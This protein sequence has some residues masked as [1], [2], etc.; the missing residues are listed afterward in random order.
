MRTANEL[1]PLEVKAQNGKSKSLKHLI[2]SDK[3]TDISYGIK[4]CAGNIGVNDNI[5]TFP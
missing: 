3:Y 4:L 1:V 2:T 5:Y